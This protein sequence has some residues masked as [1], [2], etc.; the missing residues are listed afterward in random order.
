MFSLQFA[1]SV[2]VS[3]PKREVNGT[4]L[5][6]E[7]YSE[8]QTHVAL[9][10]NGLHGQLNESVV[11]GVN[12]II[13]SVLS[14]CRPTNMTRDSSILTP[15]ASDSPLSLVQQET[16]GFDEFHPVIVARALF[17]VAV[18][19]SFLRL[20]NLLLVSDSVGPLRISLGAMTADF[21]KFIAIFVLVWLAFA[22]GLFQI[23]KTSATTAE[24]M[25]YSDG[26]GPGDC[27]NLVGFSS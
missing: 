18:T 12:V 23:Y 8:L 16:L 3:R 13:T 4:F 9:A 15:V 1:P 21:L 22:I 14:G 24:R 2:S 25:C 6:S 17:G 7:S 5:N 11:E 10:L 19:V 26:G 20:M 27:T